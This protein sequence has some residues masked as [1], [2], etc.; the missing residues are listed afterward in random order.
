MQKNLT[1][2]GFLLAM[3]LFAISCNNLKLNKNLNTKQK[4]QNIVK[5][6]EQLEKELEKEIKNYEDL[7]NLK[8]NQEDFLKKIF[9]TKNIE[10][11]S[12]VILDP[13]EKE[14]KEE[15]SR[16]KSGDKA[17]KEELKKSI[18]SARKISAIITELNKKEEELKT[19]H[20]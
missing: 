6:I 4:L 9:H 19:V 1:F 12:E 8:E 17:K 16:G 15:E 2:F 20:Q 3:G 18:Q 10:F 13:Q 5:E 11:L 14:L 7:K